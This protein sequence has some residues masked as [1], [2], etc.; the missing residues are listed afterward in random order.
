MYYGI[1][2]NERKE[3]IGV[4]MAIEKMIPIVDRLEREGIIKDK[5]IAEALLKVPRDKFVP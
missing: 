1:Y 5:K 4:I 3:I 2:C